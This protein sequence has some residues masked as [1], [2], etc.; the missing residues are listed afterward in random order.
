MTATAADVVASAEPPRAVLF[1]FGGVLTGSVFASFERFSREECGD[2]DALVRALTD[3]EEARAALVDH[4]CGRIEDEAFEEAVA[5]ALA[6]RGT[7]VESQ[8]LIA[9]MQ[10]DLHPDHA[11][12]GLVR[13]LKDEGIAVALVSNSLGRDCYTGHGLDE[14]FDVQAISGRE[15]VRKPSRALYEIACERLG[16]RPSEAIMIDD[17]AMNIRA[18]AAL[19]L[20][21]IVHRDAA[22]T[23]PA[24]T[25]LLGLAP[26][27]LDA[28]SSVPTT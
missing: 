23:I 28:D 14:L 24:L 13:R 10:R 26:G 3:D 12:T 2:P 1:D 22:E 6:A 16:V 27:T 21:G 20:G 18:A 19:G 8:G 4:E 11:M 25:E 5:R 15:G 9:R 7:T 17:L